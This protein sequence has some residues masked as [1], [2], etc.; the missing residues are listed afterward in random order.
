VKQT[1]M[2]DAIAER[3]QTYRTWL[4]S[5]AKQAFNELVHWFFDEVSTVENLQLTFAVVLSERDIEFSVKFANGVVYVN[6]GYYGPDGVGDEAV[7]D[8]AIDAVGT[9]RVSGALDELYHHLSDNLDVL[10]RVFPD[11]ERVEITRPAPGAKFTYVVKNAD[12]Q[13]LREIQED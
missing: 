1:L 3:R 6:E 5:G 2:L 10:A 11:A 9:A 13:T 12:D 8:A 4:L 7:I